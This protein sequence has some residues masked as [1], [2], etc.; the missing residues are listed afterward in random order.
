MEKLVKTKP[1]AQELLLIPVEECERLTPRSDQFYE[2]YIRNFGNTLWHATGSCKM[3]PSS[4]EKAVVD[5][6]LRVH[7]IKGL[8]V[9]DASIMPNIVSGN[10]NIPTTMIGEKTADLIKEDWNDQLKEK[11][12]TMTEL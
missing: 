11:Y 1:L 6:K 3:G 5:S 4:D 8:R 9:G 7:G 2:C 12:T 10:T